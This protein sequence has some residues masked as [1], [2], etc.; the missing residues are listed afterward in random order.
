MSAFYIMKYSGHAGVG[1]GT[2][3]IGKGVVVGVDVQGAKLQGN[4]TVVNG[5]M[6]GV[7][8][9]TAPPAGATLVTGQ[10][11]PGGGTFDLNFDFPAETFA[12][13]TPQPM[14]GLGGQPL[15]VVFEKVHD[16]PA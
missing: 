15:E 2:L 3:Y 1:G 10:H 12:D 9:M 6:S 7:V 14:I 11:M 16:L 8:K 13:G 5:R 4:Y